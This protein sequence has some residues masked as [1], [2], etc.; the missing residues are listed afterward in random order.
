MDICHLSREE[1]LDLPV[2]EFHTLIRHIEGRLESRK[3]ALEKSGFSLG[4]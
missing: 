2:L 3:N 4:Y 1:I